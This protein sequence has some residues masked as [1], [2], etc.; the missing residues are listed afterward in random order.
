[1]TSINPDHEGGNSTRHEEWLMDEAIRGSFPASDPASSSE[2]GSIVNQ[3]YA[4]AAAGRP[5]SS[6]AV[7]VAALMAMTVAFT[8]PG[9][10]AFAQDKAA[11][12]QRSIARF[13]QQFASLDRD[14]NGEVSRTEAE[15]NIDFTAAFDDIDI[16][17]DG[18]VTKEE[19]DRFLSLR[20]SAAR[21]S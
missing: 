18:V 4:E 11:Y 6:V 10:N 15:G 17:R 8:L 16:N 3:R 1:M 5:R 12:E 21:S 2:P 7:V 9:G 19:L 20:Y 14:R 13:E